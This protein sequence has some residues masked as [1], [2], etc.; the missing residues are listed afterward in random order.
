M[1]GAASSAVV[2]GGRF[3]VSIARKAGDLARPV[4]GTVVG[5]D[6]DTAADDDLVIGEAG[7][8]LESAGDDL[9]IVEPA[10]T[11][12]MAELADDLETVVLCGS[13]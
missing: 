5:F 1:N 7:G 9:V 2:G 13:S 10:G 11:L 3:D 12:E 6:N 4:D 8:G